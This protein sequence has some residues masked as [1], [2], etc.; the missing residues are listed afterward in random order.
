MDDAMVRG[1]VLHRLVEKLLPWYDPVVEERRNQ[2]TE[3]IRRRSIAA[4]IGAEE[5]T[6][7]LRSGYRAMG[8]RLRR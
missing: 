1:S 2:R 7:D 5:L 6:S 3:A 4:R 8:E